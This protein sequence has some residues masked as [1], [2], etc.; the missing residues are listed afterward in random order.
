M[1]ILYYKSCP[2]C[3]NKERNLVREVALHKELEYDDRYVLALPD[4]WGKEVEELGVSLPCL[5]NPKDGSTL[6]LDAE[7]D[8]MRDKVDLFFSGNSDE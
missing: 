4:I 2:N 5:Y 1:I 7:K 3:K 6:E 8:G